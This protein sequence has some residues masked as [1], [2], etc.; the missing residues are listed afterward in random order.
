MSNRP[1]WLETYIDSIGGD[2]IPSI[3]NT[4]EEEYKQASSNNTEVPNWLTTFRN[5]NL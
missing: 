3:S 2:S 1:N 4:E 5:R